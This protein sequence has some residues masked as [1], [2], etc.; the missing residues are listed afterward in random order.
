MQGSAKFWSFNVIYIK[1][2]NRLFIQFLR[3]RKALF[4]PGRPYKILISESKPD[5]TPD[6]RKGFRNSKHHISFDQ[7]NPDTVKKYDLVVPLTIQELVDQEIQR[8]LRNNPIPLP[9]TEA[10]NLCDDKN[11]FNASLISKGYARYIP[12]VDGEQTYPYILKKKVDQYGEN[13]HII[14]GPGDEEQYA[15]ALSSK[16]YFTQELIRGQ[17]EY[18]T[19]IVFKDQKIQSSLNIKYIFEGDKSIKGKDR[20]ITIICTCPYLKVFAS[21]LQDIGYEG[22]CC[23]NYKVRDGIPYIIEINPRFGGSLAPYFYLFT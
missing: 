19:H 3:L 18:A 11:L 14:D 15:E 7:I 23:F 8:L 4:S 12:K 6:I 2:R 22:L 20:S 9:S 16:D 1:L 5:W 13:T 17:S 10:V 21:I